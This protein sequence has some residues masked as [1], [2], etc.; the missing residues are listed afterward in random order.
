[1]SDIPQRDEI[2]EPAKFADHDEQLAIRIAWYYHVEGLTQKA[3]AQRLGLTRLRVNRILAMCRDS[4]IVQIRINSKLT[5]CVRLE[6]ALERRFGLKEAVVVPTADDEQ[7]IQE[8]IGHA[9]GHYLSDALADGMAI[10][11]GWGRTLRFS[12]RSVRGRKL[13]AL[14]VVSLIGS[15]THGSGVNTFE[16]VSRFAD[17]FDADRYYLAAPVFATTPASRDT[18]MAQDVLMEI[19][20]QARRVDLAFVSVGD[21]TDRSM[22]VRLTAVADEVSALREAGAVGDL[23]G[24]FL[25]AEGKLVDHSINQ[26]VISLGLEDLRTIDTVVL[27]SGGLYKLPILRGVLERGYADVLIIDET[28]AARLTAGDA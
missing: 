27:A 25:D 20:A 17:L 3:I 13:R 5:E 2:E 10:G 11:I 9:A 7:A 14:S 23:L 8:A 21:L 15:L 28:T 12:L 19:Y 6:R 16:I 26:R 24:H 22:M 18:I 1:M 4:G